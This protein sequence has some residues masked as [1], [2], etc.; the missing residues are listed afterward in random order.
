M[1]PWF[2]YQ[3]AEVLGGFGDR[4]LGC[5]STDLS[6]GGWKKEIP[7]YSREWQVS[8]CRRES[9][10][11]RSR[12]VQSTRLVLPVLKLVICN[13][14][15]AVLWAWSHCLH[16]LCYQSLSNI[17]HQLILNPLQIQ[18]NPVM[19]PRGR[20]EMNSSYSFFGGFLQWVPPPTKKYVEI[21]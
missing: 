17:F 1:F 8:Y 20:S 2:I 12:N 19:K 15:P 16:M 11:P 3:W 13:V 14:L 9:V 6:A 4:T 5:M 7:K 10:Q 18:T 21:I